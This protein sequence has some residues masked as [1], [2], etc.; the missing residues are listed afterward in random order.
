[1]VDDLGYIDDDRIL[2]R[3]PNIQRVWRT[4]GLRLRRMYNETPLCCPARATFLTGRHTFH[5]GVTRN[6]G[7]L[8]DP[9]TTLAVAL[10]D[11]GYHTIQA[12]KYLNDYSGP[13]KPVGWDHMSIVK[14]LGTATFWR[15]G[16]VV[17]YEPEFVDAATSR[18][19]VDWVRD[20]PRDQ[21]LFS[22]VSS[23]APHACA[24]TP[25]GPCYEPVVMPED[26]GA[27]ECAGIPKFK[28]P[29]YK[30]WSTPQVFPRE[31][32]D[33][34]AGWKLRTVCES[35]LVVDRMVGRLVEAQAERDRPAW[36]VFLSDNGMSW[37]QMGFPQKHVPTATRLPMYVAG[38]GIGHGASDVMLSNIDIAPTLA[39]IG[40]ATLQGADG[41]SFLRLLR[42]EPFAGRST[43]LEL[44]TTSH[45]TARIFWSAIR[46]RS[47][48]FIRWS[49]GKRELYLLTTDPWE[50]KNRISRD[51]AKAL[52]LET[53]L[54]ALIERSR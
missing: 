34:P 13:R 9:S 2:R 36:F 47:W 15:D 35:M 6:D 7:N 25:A 24:N 48:H 54:D 17:R 43:I 44:Q 52:E 21:P 41:T 19:A 28:P 50:L 1:M 31:M 30:I 38:P 42:G 4:G 20:A 22:W 10:H 49:N 32:P 37:G 18:Q 39:Q 29:N 5:H 33:W 12:G 46:T 40:G 8:L 27:A 16:E 3:L 14:S 53:R 26:Q 51:P 23:A 45:T 11:A